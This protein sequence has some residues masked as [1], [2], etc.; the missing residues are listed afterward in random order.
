LV[1]L[2]DR[3]YRPAEVSLEALPAVDYPAV[4]SLQDLP[5]AAVGLQEVAA[6]LEPVV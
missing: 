6:L 4:A 5:L 3:S 1:F 2:L